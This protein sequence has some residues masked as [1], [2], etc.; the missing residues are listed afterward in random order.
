MDEYGGN[1]SIVQYIRAVET[2]DPELQERIMSEILTYNEEDLQATWVVFQ[3]L[4][5]K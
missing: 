1:W 3:W 4:R 5:R 2:E